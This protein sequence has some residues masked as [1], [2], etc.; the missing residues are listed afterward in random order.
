[1]N[2]W[3]KQVICEKCGDTIGPWT[4]T[5]DYPT[6]KAVIVCEECWTKILREKNKHDTANI[7]DT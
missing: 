3:F 2:D 7:C 1:M 4:M 5:E 6:G